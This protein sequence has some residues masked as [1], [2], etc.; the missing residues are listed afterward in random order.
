MLEQLIPYYPSFKE[1]DSQ[2]VF[3]GLAEIHT[4]E[5]TKGVEK[6]VTK[7]EYYKHQRIEAR[8]M[9]MTDRLLKMSDPGTG[10]TGGFIVTDELIKDLT[11]LFRNFFYVTPSNLEESTKRQIICKLT[12]N[13]Y[14]N[15][16]RGFGGS[17]IAEVRRSDKESFTDNYTM[18]TY[19]EIFKTL[20]GKTVVQLQEM[21]NYS[22]FNIDEITRIITLHLVNVTPKTNNNGLVGWIEKLGCEELRIIKNIKR[23]EDLDDYRIINS[24][25]KYIQFWRLFHAIKN[26]KVI[27]ASGTPI[28]NR[29]AEFFLIMNLIEDLDHQFDV[30][31]FANN[32][33]RYNMIKYAPYLNGMISYVKASNVVARPN[34]IGTL[35]NRKYRVEYPM[36]ETSENPAIGIREY[37]SQFILYKIELH[38]FQSKIIYAN[39]QT[40]YSDQI[41]SM[42]SQYLCY[43]DKYGRTGSDANND[44][45]T[46]MD[47]NKPG[48]EGILMRQYC[49]SMFTNLVKI[50][51]YALAAA[52]AEGKPGPGVCFNYMSLTD[53][54]IGSLKILFKIAGFQVL[55]DFNFLEETGGDYCNIGKVTFR[56]LPKRCNTIPPRVVFLTGD[57]SSNDHIRSQILQIAGSKD[58]VYGEY[59]QWIGGSSVMGVGV[60][61]G[62]ALR[63][64]RPIPEWNEAK[65]RQSRD[66]VFRED[67]SDGI[68]E[69]MADDIAVKT[70][71]R[72]NIYDFDVF[73]DVYN[74]CAF[75]RYFYINT[76]DV[77]YFIKG[78]KIDAPQ[79]FQRTVDGTITIDRMNDGKIGMLIDPMKVYHLVG[80]MK[81]GEADYLNIKLVSEFA[82]NGENLQNN[83]LKK[84]KLI[85][86][87]DLGNLTMTH[88]DIIISESGILRVF[89]L[90]E[91][92][93]A[94]LADH[95]LIYHD[96]CHLLVESQVGFYQ[97]IAK[98]I[99]FKTKPPVTQLPNNIQFG[100]IPT[101]AV[102]GIDYELLSVSMDYVSPSERQYIQV[103]EK[104]FASKRILRYAKQFALDGISNTE[105]NFNPK[106]KDG[107]IEC[108]YQEC[109]YK[110]SSN[111]L[112]GKSSDAFIYE[113]GGLFWSNYEVLYS[114][115]IIDECKDKIIQMLKLKDKVT[116]SEIIDELLPNVGR[117]YFINMA[118]YELIIGKLS[119]PDSFGTTSYI[120]AN[121]NEIYISRYFPKL[122][123]AATD[124]TGDYTKKLIAVENNPDYRLLHNI[125]DS[126]ID[127]IEKIYL[128]PRTPDYDTY[129]LG[130]IVSKISQFKMYLSNLKL[131]EQCFGR[132]A[133]TRSTNP[134]HQLP[135]YMEKPIDRFIAGEI[136][137][138]RCF[139]IND[140]SGV[141]I[142][143]HNQPQV[144]IM[145]NQGKIAKLLNASDKFRIFFLDGNK[146]NWKNATVEETTKLKNEAQKDIKKRIEA[147]ITKEFTIQNPNGQIQTQNF[148]T[149]YYVTY[150]N[151]NYR[152]ATKMK[153][154]GKEFS[155][156]DASDI[157]PCIE[158]MEKSIWGIIPQNQVTILAIRNA[159]LS[160]KESERNELMLKLFKDNDLV[161]FFSMEALAPKKKRK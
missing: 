95:V 64:T 46:L 136:Y 3:N 106:D 32:V 14:I 125:D 102:V 80:F 36:D 4:L 24:D 119:I 28:N 27:L 98:A 8:M 103:E 122:I 154:T 10:K 152:L 156:F 11:N 21:Y 127:E 88:M 15:D 114:S 132:I 123:K 89:R 87:K 99:I 33:F 146:P 68:R 84:T 111:I 54:A 76:N 6:R 57:S 60:N 133:Y 144:N 147:K 117:E 52:I 30:E 161:F 131:I 153:P 93:K 86:S 157:N 112:S 108:D 38:G 140:S 75:C 128:D 142:F 25:I 58:N 17:T 91:E 97:D 138:I 118:I 31:L 44:N 5:A 70:G 85:I 150:Y 155:S 55:E 126:I 79:P 16:Q 116:I 1:N 61:V 77:G 40:I 34:Y 159:V 105:R 134:A 13:K 67:S 53:T 66:R 65:D 43:V 96:D 130:A 100:T 115:L 92:F 145:S 9:Q 135:E 120:C 104:S 35:L 47:L 59:I 113:G 129:M 141:K 7:G 121:N 22:V 149:M 137:S 148:S 78:N 143:F 139:G 41:T 62:N 48:F 18:I 124:N 37:N 29:G 110:L 73:I 56:G 94:L 45:I 109:K 160:G 51:Y 39:R 90:N 49:C 23:I 42:T 151:G 50:E 26:S 101:R 74:M 72:P 71:V 12:N 83:I 107:S 2:L 158:W 81:S 20:Q 69:I 63:M 19:G 82:N